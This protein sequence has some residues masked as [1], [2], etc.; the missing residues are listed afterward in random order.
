MLKKYKNTKKSSKAIL[1]LGNYKLNHKKQNI[2]QVDMKTQ[3][4]HLT[5]NYVPHEKIT[6][7]A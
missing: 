4:I 6:C 7:S 5:K 2:F 3:H 1:L